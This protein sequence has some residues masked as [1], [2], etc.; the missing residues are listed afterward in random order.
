MKSNP[1]RAVP[2]V[3]IQQNISVYRNLW[4]WIWKNS[5]KTGVKLNNL[6]FDN[7]RRGMKQQKIFLWRSELPSPANCYIIFAPFMVASEKLLYH[8]FLSASCSLFRKF[9]NSS[10]KLSE[11]RGCFPSLDCFC[12]TS[13]RLAGANWSKWMSFLENLSPCRRSF[14][15]LFAL[16]LLYLIDFARGTI[17]F[18]RNY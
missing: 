1:L 2:V 5:F 7:V 3:L 10:D 18:S 8:V 9:F 17:F 14:I 6:H 13:C 11:R 4:R 12:R 16:S 15:R